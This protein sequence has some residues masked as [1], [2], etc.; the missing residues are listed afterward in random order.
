MLVKG[1]ENSGLLR[2]R[3]IHTM[4]NRHLS[5]SSR[6][7]AVKVRPD[8]K[9][10]L[11]AAAAL[12]LLGL[13]IAILSLSHKSEPAEAPAPAET[14][15]P[16]ETTAAPE[17]TA[18]PEPTP[19]ATDQAPADTSAQQTARQI[20][21]RDGFPMLRWEVDKF[22]FGA[23]GR[24]RYAGQA[25][26]L[27]GIDVSEHQYDIDWKKVAADGVDFAMIRVGY[28]GSTA[29]GLY[30]DEYFEKNIKGALA[31]GVKVGVYF[32][33]QAI[34]AREAAEEAAFV[35]EQIKPYEIT[36]P[37]VFDWEI[38]GG[39]DARTYTV[40]R[41]TLCDATRAFC[42]TVKAAGYEP[43][44]YFTR[45]LGYRKYILRNLADYGF[46]YAEYEEQP[47]IAFDFDMWQYS[48]SGTV[49]GID[50]NVDMNL[51][52]VR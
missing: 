2:A 1:P 47:R 28:R 24:M 26:T 41:Q 46:W 13:V 31:A 17:A 35:L 22:S 11:L 20:L 12:V 7:T 14:A 33:S 4:D 50:G 3:Q 25:R 48:E 36:F 52:F 39:S 32:F 30:V 29:G 6:G 5:S 42:D 15:A 10:M 49:Q 8:K 44:L 19:D 40:S 34:D 21:R 45:Y 43:M 9:T 51:Y 16:A 23:D 18:T 38:V 37:V 27:T